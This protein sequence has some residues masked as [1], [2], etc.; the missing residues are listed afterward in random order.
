MFD[1]DWEV[2]FAFLRA[3]YDSYFESFGTFVALKICFAS[4]T[5]NLSSSTE[6]T[7]RYFY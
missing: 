4:A 2:G 6:R 1:I 7:R 3:C 5:R